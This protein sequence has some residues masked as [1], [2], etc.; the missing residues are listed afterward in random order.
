MIVSRRNLLLIWL[1][2]ILALLG[3]SYASLPWMLVTMVKHSL[4]ARGLSDIRISA[5]YPHWRGI[6]LHSIDFTT[7]AGG[8][9]FVCQIADAEIEYHL[10]EL[11]RGNVTRVRVPVADVQI[12]PGPRRAAPGQRTTALPL[13]ALMSGQWL[14][15]LPVRELSLDRLSVDWHV[16]ADTAFAVQLSGQLQDA[17]LEVN[18]EISLPQLQH[19]ISFSFNA[20]HT[21]KAD[22]IIS[23]ADH[24]A[25]PMLHVAV[26]SADSNHAPME[27]NGVLNARLNALVPVLAPW[28]NG[29][30]QISGIEGELDTQWQAHLEDSNWQITGEATIHALGGR[31]HQLAMPA[32]ELAARFTVDSQQVSLHTTLST[33]AQAVVLQAE[34]LHQFANGSGHADIKLMPVAFSDSGFVLSRLLRTWPY[35]FDI[36]AGRLSG[37]G[38]LNWQKTLQ[39]QID[40]R[41]DKLGGHYNKVI[42]TGLSGEVGLVMHEGISTSKDAQLRVDL[43]N[44][45]FPVEKI[46]VQFSLAPHPGAVLPLV[47]V[48]KFNAELLGGHA[49]TEPFEL[50]FGKDKNTFV[51]ELEHISLNEIMLLEQ[52]DGLQ[53]SGMLD[54]QIP[55]T[56]TPEGIAVAKGQLSARAPGGIIRYTPTPK[57]SVLAQENPSV[58]I[59]VKALSDFHYQ[60]MNVNSS[61]L[62]NGDLSLQVHLEGMNPGWQAGQPIHLNLNLQ[63]NIPT[64]L[65]S[66]QLSDEI[67][68]RLRKHY[69]KPP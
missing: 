57:V 43:L 19:P 9:Q 40:L 18:G 13:A 45:G 2:G 1:G 35:P 63:E 7:A 23:S 69:D 37:S 60:V 42:F 56:I 33:T 8:H 27:V 11:L 50:N 24:A 22:L 25:K 20:S 61:Y 29:I 5:D 15:Q 34:G 44:V 17:Q 31:W 4:A 48:Q 38:R 3:L 21:G 55:L 14:A 26:T 10:T 12:Q 64:L 47:R 66:L 52:Q 67:S 68:E 65:R 32:S 39:S 28:L 53:G 54:G 59:I 51:L 6:R 36:T 41:L 62:P 46:N 49:R 16:A 58:D 30:N